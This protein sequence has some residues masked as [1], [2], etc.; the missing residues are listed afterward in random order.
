MPLKTPTNRTIAFESCLQYFSSS[1][2]LWVSANYSIT[3]AIIGGV[4][5]L[6]RANKTG[7]PLPPEQATWTTLQPGADPTFRHPGLDPGPNTTPEVDAGS[8]AGMTH[9]SSQLEARD[10]GSTIQHDGHV[11]AEAV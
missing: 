3:A 2:E 4:Y 5:L 7:R 6:D 9:E 1:P 8:G 10:P 11:P